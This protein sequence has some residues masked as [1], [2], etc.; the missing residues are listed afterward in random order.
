MEIVII[1]TGNTASVLG[2]MLADAPWWS[3]EAS[4]LLEEGLRRLHAAGVDVE[5]K[6]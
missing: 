2:R 4:A 1:G 3:P 5:I 6:L